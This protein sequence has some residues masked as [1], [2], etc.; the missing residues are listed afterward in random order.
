MFSVTG[1]F[2]FSAL[3]NYMQEK[4]ANMYLQLSER[5]SGSQ[6]AFIGYLKAGS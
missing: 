1:Q 3:I 4:S 2:L 6:A 5:S